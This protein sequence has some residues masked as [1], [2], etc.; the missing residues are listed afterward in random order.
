MTRKRK[1]KRIQSG[2]GHLEKWPF[3]R[4]SFRQMADG[5]LLQVAMENA[6]L[7]KSDLNLRLPELNELF[8][9]CGFARCEDFLRVHLRC[10]VLLWRISVLLVVSERA[11]SSCRRGRRFY[12][13]AQCWYKKANLPLSRSQILGFQYCLGYL[14]SNFVSWSWRS[15]RQVFERIRFI[16]FWDFWAFENMKKV[17]LDMMELYVFGI[18]QAMLCFQKEQ[19]K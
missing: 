13:G 3:Q 7:L 18:L 9:G 4:Y 5:W 16:F 10:I 19:G 8:L 2:S 12:N 11:F 17:L 14:R 15:V 1:K 6:T